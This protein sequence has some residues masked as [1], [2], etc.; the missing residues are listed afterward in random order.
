[1]IICGIDEAGRGPVLGPL[2]VSGVFLNIKDESKLVKLGV[3]DSKRLSRKRRTSLRG[4]IELIADGSIILP[5]WPVVID[6]F[7]RQ[8]QLD[9]LEAQI[10]SS[11]IYFL[12]PDKVFIDAP[13]NPKRFKIVLESLFPSDIDVEIVAESNADNTYP[14]VSAASILAK[15]TRDSIVE[16][17]HKRYGDFGSGYPSSP[18]TRTWLQDQINMGKPLPYFVRKSWKTLKKLGYRG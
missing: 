11:I 15:T 8:H 6:N 2:V 18:L 9:L 12:R 13:G 16:N 10:M 14:V 17:L 1:M 4:E 7:V 5:V 3:R